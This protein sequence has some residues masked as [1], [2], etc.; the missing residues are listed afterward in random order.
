MVNPSS[1]QDGLSGETS[2]LESDAF[3]RSAGNGTKAPLSEFLPYIITDAVFL[4]VA[5]WLWDPAH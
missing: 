5:F 4:G 3:I 1:Q 2:N